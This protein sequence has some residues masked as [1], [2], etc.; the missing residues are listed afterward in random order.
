MLS[1]ALALSGCASQGIEKQTD[2]KENNTVLQ[3]TTE[4][5][6]N[7][8]K[9]ETD[10][11]KIEDS[12]D[13]SKNTYEKEN[14]E[15]TIVEIKED[16]PIVESISN[17]FGSGY[18]EERVEPNPGISLTSYRI[19]IQQSVQEN[20]YYCVPACLQMVL[21]VHGIEV[22]QSQLAKEMNTSSVTGTE[23]VDL[24]RIVNKYC[25]GSENISD[26]QP[27]Y[28]IQN[29]SIGDNSASTLK[30]LEN[31]ILMDMDSN[32]PVFIAVDRAYLYPKLS[33]GNHMIILVGYSVFTGTNTIA[34][35]YIIDPSYVV[36]DPAYGGLKNVTPEELLDAIAYN[37]EPA[38]IW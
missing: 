36:Q 7:N 25:F 33:H 4:K 16:E 11:N 29:L 27:G 10:N 19:P 21:R 34:N 20:G 18:S 13:I 31:R 23:Y 22:S 28:H 2:E 37:E 9:E 3:D 35:Y 12:S 26:N 30:T 8:E 24:Q 15:Q 6:Q 17:P 1:V 32:D 5:K 38:Y 14:N